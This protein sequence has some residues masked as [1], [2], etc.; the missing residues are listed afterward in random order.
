MSN[1]RPRP[2]RRIFG[3]GSE[4]LGKEFQEMLEPYGAQAVPAAAKNPQASYAERVRQA[5]GSMA[6][7][8]ELGSKHE[9]GYSGPWPSTL[10][11]CAWAARPA[12]RAA[13]SAAPAQLILGR[14]MLLG[15]SFRAKWKGIRKKRLDAIKTKIQQ[16][17]KENHHKSFEH[18]T[19]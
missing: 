7:A 3:G 5:L 16:E 18:H 6:R 12:A 8:Y 17:S 10:A 19:C 2:K 14:D 1:F 9:L 11:S 15:L 4:L 13:M